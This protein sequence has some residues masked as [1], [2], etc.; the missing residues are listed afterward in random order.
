MSVFS[1]EQ[2]YASFKGNMPQ[3][4]SVSHGY[5]EAIEELQRWLDLAY[6]PGFRV[7]GFL[8]HC[9]ALSPVTGPALYTGMGEGLQVVT[10]RWTCSGCRS[11]M[12]Q[13]DLSEGELTAVYFPRSQVWPE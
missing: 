3:G 9:G 8:H 2:C 11:D 6:I 4:G 5:G 12:A 13:H 10:D 7:V 1:C